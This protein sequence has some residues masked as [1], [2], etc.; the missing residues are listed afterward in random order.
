MEAT[1]NTGS[2]SASD[3]STDTDDGP[4]R[5][6]ARPHRRCARRMQ[7]HALPRE[8][9]QDT[10]FAV[11]V[12]LGRDDHRVQRGVENR[13]V[14]PES[15]RRH[16]GVG[17]AVT[18]RRKSRRRGA[19]SRSALG[20]PGHSRSRAPPTAHRARRCRPASRLA[21]ATRQARCRA[22]RRRVA[23]CLRRAGSTPSA[24][25]RVTRPTPH[26]GPIRR[27][28]STNSLHR[29]R[30]C[31]RDHQRRRQ[32]QLVDDRAADLVT[33]ADRHLDKAGTREDDHS[34]DRVIGQPA[35]RPR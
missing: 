9:H 30:T 14:H 31:C 34:A 26:G 32:R 8:R 13:R 4:E 16:P 19:T 18:R 15:G 7:R 6:D 33:G 1:D 10:V 20:T 3:S 23:R 29:D 12:G 28:R 2:P 17:R 5:H 21:V 11:V 22:R 24:R 35:L 25:R 27:R